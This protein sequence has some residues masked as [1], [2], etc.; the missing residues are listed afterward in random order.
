MFL[1]RRWGAKT[2]SARW[3]EKSTY[4]GTADFSTTVAPPGTFCV[5]QRVPCTEKYVQN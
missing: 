1:V 4:S 3:C 2:K 5:Y